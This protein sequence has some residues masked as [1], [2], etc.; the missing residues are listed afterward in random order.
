MVVLTEEIDGFVAL[1][2]AA[3]E[4]LEMDCQVGQPAKNRAAEPWKHR[5]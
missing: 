1:V 2:F 5:L 4:E 3:D